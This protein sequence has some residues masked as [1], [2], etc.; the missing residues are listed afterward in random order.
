MY[1]IVQSNI[2]YNSQNLYNKYLDVSQNGPGHSKENKQ[3]AT[4][5][6][7]LTKLTVSRRRQPEWFRLH[8]SIYINTKQ[9]KELHALRV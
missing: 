4:T 3:Y 8:D 6:M 7:N 1:Q 2:I 5:W 9:L